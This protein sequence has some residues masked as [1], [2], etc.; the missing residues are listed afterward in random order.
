MTMRSYSF[1]SVRR[2]FVVTENVRSVPGGAGS[3]PMRPPGLVAF[4]SRTA[5]TT[6]GTETP[7]C[8]MR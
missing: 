4:C 3:R 8:A 7:S 5:A 1:G 2:P 6:S